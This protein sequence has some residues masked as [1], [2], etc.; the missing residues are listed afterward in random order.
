MNESASDNLFSIEFILTHIIKKFPIFLVSPASL[1]I[2][3]SLGEPS[4]ESYFANR[5]TAKFTEIFS[6]NFE[7]KI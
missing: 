7:K 5:P 6:K 4:P 2:R 1:T 3:M